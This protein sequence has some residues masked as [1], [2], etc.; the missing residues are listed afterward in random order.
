[1][2]QEWKIQ[3][4]VRQIHLKVIRSS[5]KSI[6]LE[7]R[8]ADEVYIRVPV[9]LSD[10]E[11]TKFAEEHRQWILEKTKLVEIRQ[12]HRESTGATPPEILS[13]VEIEEIKRKIGSRVQ[14]Y[15]QVM[16]VSVGRIT[17]RNQKTR[18]GS[19]SGKGNLNFNY[20]LYYLPDELL[21]YVVVHE[22]AH[23]R[24]MNHS[25]EFWAEVEKYCP[26]YRQC[27]ERLKEYRL[28]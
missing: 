7:V 6:G 21:D 17:I 13:P 28:V 14:Y 18:W 26:A 10:K 25:G 23:R 9:G 1:M 3:D 16:G 22:L 15:C 2:I 8:E 12:N 5:R 20:Q 11:I 24:Y 27:R 4:G 19:C